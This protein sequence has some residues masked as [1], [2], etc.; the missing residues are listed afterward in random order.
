MTFTIDSFKEP[1]P[2]GQ[3]HSTRNPVDSFALLRAPDCNQREYSS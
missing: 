1:A 3:V 2:E